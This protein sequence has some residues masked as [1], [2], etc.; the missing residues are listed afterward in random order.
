[1]KVKKRIIKKSGRVPERKDWI[2]QGDELVFIVMPLLLS[3]IFIG[4]IGMVR[5][6]DNAMSRYQ[7]ERYETVNEKIMIVENKLMSYMNTM[8]ALGYSEYSLQTLTNPKS[9]ENQE[10]LLKDLYTNCF[11]DE[12]IHPAFWLLNPSQK[13]WI[14]SGDEK[15]EL[16]VKTEF[17]VRLIDQPFYIEAKS[18]ES[19][20]LSHGYFDE[21]NN[22]MISIVYPVQNEEG[23]LVAACGLD[24]RVSE[25]EAVLEELDSP[26]EEVILLGV[27]GEILYQKSGKRNNLLMDMSSVEHSS[28]IF[29]KIDTKGKKYGSFSYQGKKYHTVCLM[30]T[31]SGLQ[32]YLSTPMPS[33][34]SVGKIRFIHYGVCMLFPFI[35]C[36]GIQ[37]MYLMKRFAQLHQLRSYISELADGNLNVLP[38]ISGSN[39]VTEIAG[40]IEQLQEDFRKMVREMKQ[41]S[42][43]MTKGTNR[44]STQV[45]ALNESFSKQIELTDQLALNSRSIQKDMRSNVIANRKVRDESGLFSVEIERTNSRFKELTETMGNVRLE[46]L[47]IQNIVKSIDDISFQ[48]GLLAI[49]ANVEAV[50]GKNESTSFQIIAGQIRG[51]ADECNS[52]AQMAGQLFDDLREVVDH[53]LN[54]AN[55]SGM[56]MEKAV[57]EGKGINQTAFSMAEYAEG[58]LKSITTITGEVQRISALISESRELTKHCLSFSEELLSITGRMDAYLQKYHLDVEE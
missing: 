11:F 25:L 2:F 7:L 41:F 32:Y 15:K 33:F 40:Y 51:L 10:K 9:G 56:S 52:L 46:F 36:A 13:K 8:N 54:V 23:V 38:E 1:M 31:S 37:L 20:F 53:S 57:E 3:I 24:F 55:L 39:D 16:T 45:K 49:N 14:V 6:I 26:A 44:L 30:K 19:C 47:E 42:L 48:T 50:R 58:G 12:D 22:V 5:D 43:Q 34:F 29:A 27:S 17:S 18:K 4:C 21:E 28:E 35:L